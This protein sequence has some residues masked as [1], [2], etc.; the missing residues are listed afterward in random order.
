VAAWS[1]EVLNADE[2]LLGW[3]RRCVATIFATATMCLVMQQSTRIFTSDYRVWTVLAA[4]AATA[5]AALLVSSMWWPLRTLVVT[6]VAAA[7]SAGVIAQADGELPTDLLRAVTHGI[8]DVAGT[9]WPSPPLA[10]GVGALALLGAA[11]AGLA[12]DLVVRRNPVVAL[13]PSLTAAA[14]I[15]LLSAPAGPPDV[16]VL[17]AYIVAALG[18]LASRSFA[19]RSTIAVLSATAVAIVAVAVPVALA[20][21][22]DATRYD[23]RLEIPPPS[24]PRLG[25]SP[26]ARL[27]E[28]RSRTPAEPVFATTLTAPARWRLVG[29]TRYDGRTWLPADDYR[30]AG[31]VIAPRDLAQPSAR[32]GVQIAA[33]DAIW[34][35]SF[36][37]T[38]SV[39]VGAS[40]DAGRSGVLAEVEP[41]AGTA[42][43]LELQPL[44]IE[45][46]QLATARVAPAESP[47]IDGFELSAELR[48]LATSITAGAR[49]DAERAQLIASYLRD[50]FV[51]DIDSPPGHSIAVLELFID[52]SRRGRDEQFVAAY[53]LLAAAVGLPVRIAVGF[54]TAAS[55]DGTTVAMSDRVTAWPEVEFDGFGWVAF[56]P[57]PASTNSGAPALG[58]GAI[59]PTDDPAEQRPPT[60]AAT[61]TQ[62]TVP[63]TADEDTAISTSS[64]PIP[65]AAVGIAIVSVGLVLGVACYI[66]L[67]IMLKARRR[68]RRRKARDPRD[69]ALG[70]FASSIEVLI[71]LGAPAPRSATNAELVAHG[72]ST[73][74]ESAAIL[75]PVAA[76]ATQAIYAVDPPSS[77]Q[78]DWAWVSA[79]RFES[80]AAGQMSRLKRLRAKTST[81]SLRRGWR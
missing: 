48:E 34:L 49:T 79:E 77:E 15:A 17:A 19:Y 7:S 12:V 20:D 10:A 24:D 71:D 16:W 81:R 64:D 70:A 61:T 41:T 54:D 3:G 44:D 75:A 27:D 72:A 57:V 33:L 58:D 8:S 76:L 25:I 13:L 39:S 50:E 62:T 18:V 4:T 69:R 45:P 53:G 78:T 63:D 37:T 26:L 66:G 73:V 23:P 11:G 9:I 36:D 55:A 2:R 59:A 29:L 60:T 68:G 1:G 28:W 38:L 46:A 5:L 65:A 52:Q 47:F 80:E 31:S 43:E 22:L 30:L 6:A 32:V 14:L 40:V 67:I 56:D 21:Q 35:P 42:Y 51:L 74:G